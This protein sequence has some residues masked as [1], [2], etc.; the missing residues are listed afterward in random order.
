MLPG[1]E[2]DW[3]IASE[4]LSLLLTTEA[5]ETVRVV[6]D[7]IP[8]RW[9]EE[10]EALRLARARLAVWEGNPELIQSLVFDR[11]LAHIREGETPLAELWNEMCVLRYCKKHGIEEITDDE[12]KKVLARNPIPPEYDFEMKLE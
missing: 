7:S 10:S 8:P 5:F 3:A 6:F 2:E 4:Y 9:L 12:R 1:F 11:T